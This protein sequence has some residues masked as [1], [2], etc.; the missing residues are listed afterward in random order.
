MSSDYQWP[1]V[2]HHGF[3]KVGI[4][5]SLNWLWCSWRDGVMRVNLSS[6]HQLTIKATAVL[7]LMQ[8]HLTVPKTKLKAAM[9]GPQE[10]FREVLHLHFSPLFSHC[11]KIK[12]KGVAKMEK[13]K[14]SGSIHDSAKGNHRVGV[15]KKWRHNIG[16]L[17]YQKLSIKVWGNIS[18]MNFTNLWL[19]HM[20]CMT[21]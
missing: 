10:T 12:L 4:A 14:D 19:L 21:T 11:V 5:S 17:K 13:S 15:R 7:G 16:N 1:P 18:G 6:G 8:V 2:V 20:Y 3:T 9:A